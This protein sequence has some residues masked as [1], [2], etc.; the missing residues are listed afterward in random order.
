[1]EKKTILIVDDEEKNVK[2]MRAILAAEGYHALPA[3]GGQEALNVVSDAPPDLIL[4]DIM[5]P[6]INGF[7]VCE[8]LKGNEETRSIPIVMVTALK[9]KEHR[10]KAMELGADDF[11]TKPVDHVELLIRVKSL[12][13]IKSYHDDLLENN[14][15]L[16]MAYEDLR[17]LEKMKEGLIHLIIHDLQNPLTAISANLELVLMKEDALPEKEAKSIEKGLMSC[18]DLHQLIQSLL[19]VHKMEEGKLEVSKEATDITALTEEVIDNNL[20]KFELTSKALTFQNHQKRTDTSLDPLLIKRVLGNLISNAHK[21]TPKGG[22]VTVKV[23][24]LH[25][26]KA[27]CVSVTDNGIGIEP[28]F[29]EK[30][31]EKFEQVDAKNS[32]MKIGGTGLGLNF[33]KAAVQAHGGKIWIES[34]G[35]GKGS[36]FLFTIPV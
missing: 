7:E 20:P 6:G 5:M 4:L 29:H 32:E 8:R 15:K 24:H 35:K 3:L 36:T 31:F 19:D 28:E 9:E 23:D 34:E 17:D 21:N 25:N 27:V 22:T 26:E 16:L 12:L 30:I 33:C 10:L 2:L 14:E 11:L 18:H 1:M 13:R